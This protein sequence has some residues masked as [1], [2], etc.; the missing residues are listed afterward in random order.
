MNAV[1]RAAVDN[2]VARASVEPVTVVY[3]AY[4]VT[5]LDVSW[6]DADDAV[7]VVHNDDLLPLGSIEHGRGVDL[8]SRGNVG[9]GAAVNAALDLVATDRVILC[10]PDTQLTREHRQLLGS[11]GPDELVTVALDDD[12]GEPTWVV[13]PYPGALAAVEMANLQTAISH[14]P[15]AV[16]KTGSRSKVTGVSKGKAIPGSKKRKRRS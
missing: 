6:L 3:V 13:L 1:Q 15:S 11:A 10:N 16:R 2:P 7:I 14:Q 8:V 9:F 4:G 12:L 5:T